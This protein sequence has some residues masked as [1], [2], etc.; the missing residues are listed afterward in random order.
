MSRPNYNSAHFMRKGWKIM[1]NTKI[2]MT[3]DDTNNL[4]KMV[5]E[6]PDLPLIIF[7][8]EEGWSGEYSYNSVE[9]VSIRIEELTYEGEYY[10]EKDEFKEKLLDKY[11]D[12]YDSDTELEKFATDIMDNKEFAKAIVIYVG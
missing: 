10:I 4:R 7:V 9:V 8:G 5:M 3:L 6:N 12:K 11:S 1:N 2:G